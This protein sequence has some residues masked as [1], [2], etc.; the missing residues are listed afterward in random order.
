VKQKPETLDEIM[1]RRGITTK[2]GEEPQIV[3]IT[4]DVI[5]SGLSFGVLGSSKRKKSKAAPKDAALPKTRS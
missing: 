5:A 4:D 1:D 2:P 3:D